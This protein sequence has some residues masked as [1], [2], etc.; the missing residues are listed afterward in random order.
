MHNKIT[1]N[2]NEPWWCG[3]YACCSRGP[4]LNVV[5]DDGRLEGMALVVIK[6]NNQSLKVQDPLVFNISIDNVMFLDY[7]NLLFERRV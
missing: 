2:P 3:E 1:A 5:C 6:V 4:Q 7:L